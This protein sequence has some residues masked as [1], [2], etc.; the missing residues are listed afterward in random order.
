[1]PGRKRKMDDLRHA[2][3]M[4]DQSKLNFS[5]SCNTTDQSVPSTQAEDVN[6]END[7][8]TIM[9]DGLLIT[10][11]VSINENENENLETAAQEIIQST[12]N[13]KSSSLEISLINSPYHPDSQYKFKRTKCGSQNRSCV[14]KWFSDPPPDGFPWLHYRAETD[15]VICYICHNNYNKGN[16]KDVANVEKAFISVGF[17]NWKKATQKF[18]EHQLSDCHL[19]SLTYENTVSKCADIIDTVSSPAAQQ[20]Q[21]ERKY[22]IKVMECVKFLGRQG[23]AFQGEGSNDNFTQL[24]L[25][26]CNE[27][28]KKRISS[29]RNHHKKKMSHSDYQ[30]ELLDLMAREV[31]IMLLQKVKTSKFFAIMADE[32]TDVSNN[33]NL[34]ICLRYIDSKSLKA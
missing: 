32:G 3:N 6:M 13:V 29:N 27:E 33:E 21:Q 34:S 14:S 22:F 23:I 12:E 5:T 28:E 20:R 25:F 24:L 16:L 31:L 18:N 1:M 19:A 9:E 30:N 10:P 11:D 2:G 26:Q 4:K 7:T 17:S 8:E 15:T